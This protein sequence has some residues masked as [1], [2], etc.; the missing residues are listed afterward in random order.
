MLIQVNTRD[1]RGPRARRPRLEM[2]LLVAG[3]ANGAHVRRDV[4][5]AVSERDDVI[6]A[7]SGLSAVGAAPTVSLEDHRPVLRH[8]SVRVA[9]A[10]LGAMV[11]GTDGRPPRF[12]PHRPAMTFPDTLRVSECPRLRGLESGG[13]TLFEIP[14]AVSFGVV[15]GPLAGTGNAAPSAGIDLPDGRCTMNGTFSPD[16]ARP[17]PVFGVLPLS[18]RLNLVGILRH[19][20]PRCYDV[21]SFAVPKLPV[22]IPFGEAMM[23]A[24]SNR[25]SH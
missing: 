9:S 10:F 5:P 17:L 3:E 24:G 21:T 18:D 14:G 23:D 15:V 7:C 4:L 6:H 1:H 19:P 12:S 11:A 2:L 20:L 22:G 13:L 25:F 8:R 16:R